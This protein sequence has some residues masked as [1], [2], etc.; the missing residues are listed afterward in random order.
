MQNGGQCHIGV[1]VSKRRLDVFLPDKGEY[2]SFKNDASGHQKLN[3]LAKQYAACLVTLEATGGYEQKVVRCLQSA[4]IPVAIVNAKRVRDFAK[5]LGIHAKTD[6]IDAR[7]ISH[8][9][10]TTQPRAYRSSAHDID[11]LKEKNMRRSQLVALRK[12]EKQ[13]LENASD[14][15]RESIQASISRI[16][17][18]IAEIEVLLKQLIDQNQELSS[19]YKL[20]LSAKGVGSIVAINLLCYLPELGQLNSKEI[21]AMVGVAPFNKDSGEKTGQRRTW[22]GRSQVRTALYLSILSAKNHN[23]TIKIFFDRLV[24]RGKKPQVAMIACVRKLL[25]I[26]NAMVKHNTPWRDPVSLTEGGRGIP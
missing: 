14:W 21:A 15:Q 9:A 20:L 13:S 8:F 6:K 12:Q 24:H 25:V 22:G 16:K 5:A 4:Q 2:K 7:V 19:Q 10:Q 11:E 23:P 26:L 17:K 18:E 3:G 1:D